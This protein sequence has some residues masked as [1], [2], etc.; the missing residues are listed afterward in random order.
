MT[1]SIVAAAIMT[2]M[3]VMTATKVS[4][5]H[6]TMTI[7]RDTKHIG[8][9]TTM[10]GAMKCAVRERLFASDKTSSHPLS[11]KPAGYCPAGFTVIAPDTK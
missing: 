11:D 4:N 5:I 2:P 6:G 7:G 10:T 1:I 8:V 9:S 3:A